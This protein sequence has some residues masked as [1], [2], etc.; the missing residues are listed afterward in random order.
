MKNKAPAIA[1]AVVG[2][3]PSLGVTSTAGGV[4]AGIQLLWEIVKGAKELA[5]FI[6]H[7]KN[8]KWFQDSHAVFSGW[9]AA[10]TPE[11]KKRAAENLRD[12]LRRLG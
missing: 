6:E 10:K 12:L 5:A 1:S 8:E 7:N 4:L 2:A 9:K 3:S 11:E